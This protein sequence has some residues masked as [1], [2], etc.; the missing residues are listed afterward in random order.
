MLNLMLLL[1][2]YMSFTRKPPHTST[3]MG[4]EVSHMSWVEGGN[5][6]VIRVKN[7]LQVFL[8]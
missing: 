1:L 8:M 2:N 3:E 4:G 6:L 5:V 7:F